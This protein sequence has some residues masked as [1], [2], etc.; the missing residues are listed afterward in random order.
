MT[1]SYLRNYIFPLFFIL[2]FITSGQINY[3]SIL[4]NYF[5]EGLPNSPGF[6]LSIIKNG[7]LV[8]SKNQGLSDLEHG[9]S[10]TSKSV[11]NIASLSKQFTAFSIY[12]L[13]DKGSLELDDKIH[14]Y[15]DGLPEY[16]SQITINDLIH[17]TSGIRD[18]VVLAMLA[19]HNVFSDNI[20]ENLLMDMIKRQSSLEFEPGTKFSYSN[21][22]YLL[23]AKIVETVSGQKF[24]EFTTEEIFQ[25]LNMNSTLFMDNNKVIITNRA[26]AYSKNENGH[27]ENS[28]SINERVGAGGLY[29]SGEDFAKWIE[30]IKKNRLGINKQRVQKRLLEQ[31]NLK[32]GKL[33]RYAGGLFI[34]KYKDNVR[35]SHNGSSGGYRSSFLYFP[36][37]DLSI[38]AFSNAS[39]F[40]LN[41]LKIVDLFLFEDI[42]ESGKSDAHDFKKF[43]QEKLKQYEGVFKLSSGY[44]L[45]IQVKDEHLYY[46]IS[47]NGANIILPLNDNMFVDPNTGIKIKINTENIDNKKAT[48]IYPTM[49]MPESE[50][51]NKAFSDQDYLK[52]FE[53]NFYNSDL[54]RSYEIIREGDH[55][56]I[57]IDGK[58]INKIY[59]VDKNEFHGGGMTI[60]FTNNDTYELNTGRI[61]KLLFKRI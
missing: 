7:K 44:V 37:E 1:I 11:F 42:P 25:P 49:S 61:K 9:I 16:M 34:S 2:P 3:S 51:L 55:L 39:D 28:F 15:F 31:H 35:I 56:D 4:D 5:I 48:I 13:E 32:N 8:Y 14:K 23:L 29:T 19:G 21:S 53:G 47:G 27:Y 6:H 26:F 10:I 45:L 18:H 50:A 57:Q 22:G 41:L 36:D 60:L 12:L 33:N 17:H 52:L 24:S 38:Y 20:P 43:S 46:T 59:G 40:S 58:S 30:N 54:D